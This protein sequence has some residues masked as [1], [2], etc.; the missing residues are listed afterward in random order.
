[1]RLTV[2]AQMAKSLVGTALTDRR[3]AWCTDLDD[4]DLRYLQEDLDRVPRQLERLKWFLWH[5]NVLRARQVT[6]D[7]ESAL[8]QQSNG[9]RR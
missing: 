2:L 6:G 7:L 9:Q 5:G 4:D 8:D 1:M 3:G